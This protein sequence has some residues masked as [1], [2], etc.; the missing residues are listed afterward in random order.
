MGI[1]FLKGGI[2]GN[3]ITCGEVKRKYIPVISLTNSYGY[4]IVEGR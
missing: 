3:I 1:H 2:Y 4:N